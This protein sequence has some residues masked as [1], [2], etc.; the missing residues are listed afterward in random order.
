MVRL[1]HLDISENFNTRKIAKGLFAPFGGVGN[2][3][4]ILDALEVFELR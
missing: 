4:V 2:D 1:S 3:R